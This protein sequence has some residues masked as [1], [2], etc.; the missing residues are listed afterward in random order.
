[1][2][3]WTPAGRSCRGWPGRDESITRGD[4]NVYLNAE[5]TIINLPPNLRARHLM[6][7]CG[8]YLAGTARGQPVLLG[9]DAHGRDADVPEH[10]VRLAEELFGAPLAA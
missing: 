4:W 8:L 5:G 3:P 1:M 7:E 10:L 6:H 2:N 9:R